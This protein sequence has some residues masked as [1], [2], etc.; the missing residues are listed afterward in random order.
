MQHFQMWDAEF[1]S[2]CEKTSDL[3]KTTPDQKITFVHSLVSYASLIG[4][5]QSYFAR[6]DSESLSTWI[7]LAKVI[8]VFSRD[9]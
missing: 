2:I 9:F 1:A 7:G 6:F 5:L 8:F 3:E 4:A